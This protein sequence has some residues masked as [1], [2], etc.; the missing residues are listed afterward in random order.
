M[1]NHKSALKRNRQNQKRNALNR[2]HRS[3]LRTQLRKMDTLLS[4]NNQEEVKKSVA[5]TLSALDKSVQKG[6]L[7]KN[8]ASRRKSRLMIKANALLSQSPSA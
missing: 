7:H 1:A 4:G 3:R 6:V 2:S 8:A 5:D